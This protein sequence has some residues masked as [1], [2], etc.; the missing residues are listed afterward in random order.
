MSSFEGTSRTCPTWGDRLR[1][2]ESK[3]E[4]QLVAE[5][6]AADNG[7]TRVMMT[8]N[9]S[10]LRL[11]SLARLVLDANLPHDQSSSVKRD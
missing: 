9:D 7:V 5:V 3:I 6:I 4:T 11:M 10:L 1:R 8:R 2:S